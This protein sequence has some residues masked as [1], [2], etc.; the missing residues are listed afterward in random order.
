MKRRLFKMLYFQVLAAIVLG[1]VFG[2]LWPAAGAALKPLADGFINLVKM[3]VGPVVFC[4]IV[5]GIAGMRDSMGIGRIIVKALSLFYVLTAISLVAG[6]LAVFIFQPGAGM[7]VDPAR[8]DASAAAQFTK[9]TP[10]RGFVDFLIG[11]IPQ[12]FFGA[13][14]DG[15]VL[16]IL[17]LA[18]IV[19]AAL[20]RSGRDGEPVLRL[21]DSFCQVLFAAFAMIIKLSPIG[22]FGAM[23]FTVGRYGIQSLRSLALLVTT[24]YIACIV[25]VA[26]V[27]GTL[28]ALHRFSLWKLIRY[29]QEELLIIFGTSTS[30]PVI[31]RLL[32]KL[33][34]LGCQKR[35]VGLSLPLSYSFNL[36]GI[37]IYLTVAAV[38]I[39]QACNIH[40]SLGRILSMLLLMLLTS[41]GAAGVAGSGFVA[42]V[43]TLTVMPDIP[44]AGL[45]LLIGVDR[46]MSG[47]RAV[48]STISNAV[49]TIVIAKWENACD[50]AILKAELTGI[51]ISSNE[52]TFEVEPFEVA[53]K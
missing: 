37:A 49:S 38:F 10:P 20:I 24:F 27:I 21:I 2:Y 11:I 51:P 16:P 30:E 29:F 1:A 43:A 17:L 28:A 12:S 18:I 35:I 7:N 34:R 5:L 46:F 3:M 9:Q 26:V 15:A 48:T 50:T 14:A 8:L 19:G 22:A 13:F 36:D 53:K 32:M 41:K 31:P 42:L 6:L 40:L 23:A 45:A 33:E 47:M 52:G 25:F 4:T 44:V 39:A